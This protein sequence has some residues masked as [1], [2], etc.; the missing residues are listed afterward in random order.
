[1]VT[2]AANNAPASPSEEDL[3]WMRR[4]LDLA[5]QSTGLASPNPVVGCVMVRDGELVGE[6]CHEYGKRDHAEIAAL[7]AAGERARGATAYT[8]L[9]PCSRT[10]RTGPCADALIAAGVARVVI[11]TRDPNPA[12]KSADG[13]G[14]GIE[15]LQ[16]AG[17]QV[18]T[19]ILRDEARRLNNAFARRVRSG[20]PLVTLKIAS[21]LDGRIAPA[22]ALTQAPY[23]ITGEASHAEVQKM[24]HEADVLLTGVGTIIADNPLFTDRSGLPRRRPLLR[25]VLDSHLRTPLNSRV[26][27]SAGDDLLIFYT[28]ARAETEQA[29]RDRGLQIHQLDAAKSPVPGAGGR[30]SPEAALEYLGS[31]GWNSVMIEGGAHINMAVLERDLAD[32]LVIF[33][34][35]II[36]GG[37]AIPMLETKLKPFRL[38]GAVFRQFG[39]DFAVESLLRD[40]WAGVD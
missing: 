11:A 25:A 19:G 38:P 12:E 8:T 32:R 28:Q 40:P 7:K 21:T 14:C 27:E 34:A 18:Q 39:E 26:V 3:G 15:R 24:R 16:A 37:D 13:G 10:G 23:W 17:L 33:Y 30:V 1:M 35:P 22:H 9:E 6:G 5:A 4:A 31:A 29:F 36:L 2:N 20:L